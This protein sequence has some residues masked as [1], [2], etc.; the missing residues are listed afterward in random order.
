MSIEGN[1]HMSAE[2]KAGRIAD[3]DARLAALGK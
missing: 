2:E 1:E 3:I